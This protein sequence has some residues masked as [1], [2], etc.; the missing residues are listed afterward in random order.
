MTAKVEE[1]SKLKTELNKLKSSMKKSNVLSLE[2]EAYEKS[3][4]DMAEKLEANVKQLAEV[5][6]EKEQHE[7][8]IQAL[9]ADILKL[10]NELELEKQNSNG[11]YILD[12]TDLVILD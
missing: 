5:R 1:M 3:L 10:N 6:N 12:N 7:A 8:T 2:V 4:K 11:K 9:K